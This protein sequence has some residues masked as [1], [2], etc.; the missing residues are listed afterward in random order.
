MKSGEAASHGHRDDSTPNLALEF[1][2]DADNRAIGTHPRDA[3]SLSMR[4]Q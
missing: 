2:I 3:R 4:R 1:G